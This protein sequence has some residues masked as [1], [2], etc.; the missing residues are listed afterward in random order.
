M[1]EKSCGA[2]IIKDNKVLLL[3]HNEGHW[4]YPKG[5]IENN[6]TEEETALREI[7]E[8]TNLEVELIKGFRTVITYSPKENIIK[9]VVFFLA[10]PKT[11]NIKVQKKE[12]ETYKWISLDKAKN[13]IT[14]NDDKQVLDKVISYL[15]S[16]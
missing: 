16:F 8:E 4:S 3:K 10:K 9:D 6:E 12:I 2:V 15:K 1:K 11:T 14:Y 13:L 5:H 7:K